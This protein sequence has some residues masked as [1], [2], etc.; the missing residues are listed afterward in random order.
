MVRYL[1][2]EG[3]T[4]C[5]HDRRGAVC[6]AARSGRCRSPSSYGCGRGR[7]R[8]ERSH[9]KPDGRGGVHGGRLP[10][11]P[12]HP[13]D[14]ESWAYG[15]GDRLSRRAASADRTGWGR[16]Q[17]P[18]ADGG[19][20]RSAAERGADKPAESG[21]AS[22]AG[23]EVGVAWHDPRDQRL[24]QGIARAHWSV[25]ILVD[26]HHAQISGEPGASRDHHRGRG[27]SSL[28]SSSCSPERLV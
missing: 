19:R 22:G 8:S 11:R 3:R 20:L 23:T 2:G 10:E 13:S 25:P 1:V 24:P 21:L 6:G 14:R 5:Q 16:R 9:P 27:Y 18:L 4:R 12:R 15:R 7:I 26:G 28:L 17:S